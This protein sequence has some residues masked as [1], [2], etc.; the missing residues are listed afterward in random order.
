M[1]IKSRCKSTCIRSR[2][3]K[4]AVINLTQNIL[5]RR[6]TNSRMPTAN[7]REKEEE[8]RRKTQEE[9]KKNAERDDKSETRVKR[10]AEAENSAAMTM[11]SERPANARRGYERSSH[12][13]SNPVSSEPQIAVNLR[14]VVRREGRSRSL[15]EPPFESNSATVASSRGEKRRSERERTQEEAKSTM[16]RERNGEMKN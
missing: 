1:R 15:D 2:K 3:A 5:Y 14:Q 4:K 6:A 8:E 7:R 9:T 12:R 13:T 16:R 11:T 10:P